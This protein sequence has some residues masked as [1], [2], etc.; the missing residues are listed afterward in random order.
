MDKTAIKNFAIESRRK[1]IAAIK[2]QMKVLGITEEQISDKL[3]TSTSE[4]EYYVDDRN[5]ITGS[6][7]VKRQKLVVELHERETATDYETAY[8]ELVEEVA[9]TWFNRLIA[10]RFM[11]VNGYLPSRIR[12]LC[13]E[14]KP[15]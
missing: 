1:L 14:A 5:P 2:L 15:I 8:N 7:I 4:I 13:C 12:V 9:Y 6:N 11:E 3:E 10:I